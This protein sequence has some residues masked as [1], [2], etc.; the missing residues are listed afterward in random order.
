MLCGAALGCVLPDVIHDWHMGGGRSR[1]RREVVSSTRP[2]PPMGGHGKGSNVAAESVVVGG[3]CGQT[4]VRHKRRPPRRPP[5]PSKVAT[6][7]LRPSQRLG[8]PGNAISLA[9][10]AGACPKSFSMSGIGLR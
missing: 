3:N 10:G 6:G 8:F 5:R 7:A 4:V 1:G 2:C 9:A